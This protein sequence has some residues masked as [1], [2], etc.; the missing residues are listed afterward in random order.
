MHRT[1]VSAC[2]SASALN[3]LTDAAHTLVSRLG[4][5]FKT[6]YF[7]LNPDRVM[8]ER[9]VLVKRKSGAAFPVSGS[10]PIVWIGFPFNA[11][12]AIIVD[13]YLACK[14]SKL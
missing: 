4:K 11:I 3:F 5:M 14:I 10:K 12:V 2:F 1:T 8:S 6:I 13:L 9:S 7:P